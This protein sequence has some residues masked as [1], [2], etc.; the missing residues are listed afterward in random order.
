MAT[1]DMQLRD[2]ECRKRVAANGAP[3]FAPQGRLPLHGL[4]GP[5]TKW[6]CSRTG[7]ASALCISQSAFSGSRRSLVSL[8]EG[9][10]DAC[11]RLRL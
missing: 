2:V 10:E 7:P 8:V 5:S 1:S 6:G 3:R 11:A 9:G 4:V